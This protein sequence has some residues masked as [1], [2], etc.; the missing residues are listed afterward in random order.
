M[1]D[2]CLT[3]RIKIEYN[4]MDVTMNLQKGGSILEDRKTRNKHNLLERLKT[5]KLGIVF[6]IIQFL[7]TIGLSVLLVKFKLLNRFIV[8]I[9]AIM[10]IL[11]VLMVL[12]QGCRGKAHIPF[13][14]V[15]ALLCVIYSIGS[16]YICTTYDTGTTVTNGE[17][18]DSF[19]VIVLKENPAQ[20][21]E[22]VKNE[23][24]GIDATQ[25]RES[26]D[27]TIN[28][29]QTE[30]KVSISTKE[31]VDSMSLV[32]ALY[33]KDCNV[34][35]LNTAVTSNI[36]DTY[37][38]FDKETRVL[39][40]YVQV[41]KQEN[42]EKVASITEE[43]FSVFLSGIDTYGDVSTKSRSDVNLIAT[44]NPKT[45]EILLTSTPRDYFVQTT[46]SGTQYDKLTH[47]GLYGVE[48]S[49]GTLEKLYGVKINYYAKVNF[50][51]FKDIIDALGSVTVHSD[52]TFTA[53]HGERFKEGDNV[54]DGAKALAFVRER[55]S[56]PSGDL[57]R[58]KNQQALIKAVIE[59]A[60][61]PAILTG[62][63][64]IMAAVK[65]SVKMNMSYEEIASLVQ[66]QLDDGASWH[67]STFG[68]SGEGG[69]STTYSNQKKAGYVMYIDE[70][71]VAEASSYINQVING[72][73]PSIKED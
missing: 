28:T 7:L 31:Y 65:D 26:F 4:Y 21:I 60:A 22:D 57:Q 43:P 51:G 10:L 38:N 64:D 68:V 70:E 71:K 35:I 61:S 13:K 20:T 69:S 18:K 59:K 41:T 45:K 48:C 8:I 47:A 27:K 24:F 73:V 32:E 50:T 66:M 16:Y 11:L 34:I 14:V 52:Y 40:D 72:Q 44:V 5:R 39:K 42:N 2:F 1:G 23:D 9:V 37:P 3:P 17:V 55:H 15:I 29:I 12:G 30:L 53:Q 19:Q 49:M 62:F 67:I 54:V 58:N 25:K 33:N 46:V 63:S 6:I 56:F 36:K